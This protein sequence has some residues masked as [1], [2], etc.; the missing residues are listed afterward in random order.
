MSG[1]LS[2]IPGS[3]T[4]CSQVVPSYSL[5]CWRVAQNENSSVSQAAIHRV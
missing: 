5:V 1:N 2:T 4:V 3:A